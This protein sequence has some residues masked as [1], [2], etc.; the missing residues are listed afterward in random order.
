MTWERIETGGNIPETVTVS[1][2]VFGG[3]KSSALVVSISAA[4]ATQLGL[5]KDGNSRSVIER[6]RTAGRIR[7]RPATKDDPRTQSRYSVWRNRV[8][9]I[10]VPMPE[11]EG[12]QKKLAQ[13]V[14]WDINDGWLNIKLP[15]W[16]CPMIQVS[17]KVA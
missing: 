14:A 15:H 4:V 7:L 1:W 8:C 11:L 6:N 5:S 2:R 16:A 13:E 9:N 10:P 12:L 17:G 3:R